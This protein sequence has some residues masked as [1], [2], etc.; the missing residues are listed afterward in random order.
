ME[1]SATDEIEQG[2]VIWVLRWVH[3][4]SLSREDLFEEEPKKVL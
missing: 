2:T 4:A 1:V 3:L